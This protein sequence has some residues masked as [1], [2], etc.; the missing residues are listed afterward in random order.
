MKRSQRAEKLLIFFLLL[1]MD[2]GKQMALLRK[3]L[4]RSGNNVFLENSIQ[5]MRSCH[6]RILIKSLIHRKYA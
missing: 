2:M 3:K 4:I 5:N 6:Y 1:A